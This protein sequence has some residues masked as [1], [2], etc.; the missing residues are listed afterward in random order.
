MKMKA[1]DKAML[2]CGYLYYAM[3]I[4]FGVLSL[5]FLL[6]A[7]H[8]AISMAKEGEGLSPAEK[9]ELKQAAVKKQEECLE[10][11]SM[12]RERLRLIDYLTCS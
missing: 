4:A 7:G 2:A 3:L 6:S 10:R 9:M 8:N 11:K 12:E 5:V 1:I